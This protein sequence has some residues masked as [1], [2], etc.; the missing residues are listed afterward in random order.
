MSPDSGVLYCQTRAPLNVRY[1]CGAKLW[2]SGQASFI[3]GLAEQTYPAR[4]LVLGYPFPNVLREHTR[5]TTITFTIVFWSSENLA[6]PGRYTFW[7]VWRH[8]REEWLQ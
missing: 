7:M 2:I 3:G 1:K 6:E 4:P 8:L 5:V